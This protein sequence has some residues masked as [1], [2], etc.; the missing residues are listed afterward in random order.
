MSK[1]IE[2]IQENTGH[3]TFE[4]LKLLV[5]ALKYKDIEKVYIYKDNEGWKIETEQVPNY[6]EKITAQDYDWLEQEHKS[7]EHVVDKLYVKYKN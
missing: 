1:S 4:R 3:I 5:Y 2:M 6:T 7:V